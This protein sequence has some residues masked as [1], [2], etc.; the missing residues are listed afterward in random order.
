MNARLSFLD[1][2]TGRLSFDWIVLAALIL[3]TAASVLSL[4]AASV[5]LTRA[6]VAPAACADAPA[7]P[8]LTR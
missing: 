2:E 4:P 1:A 6:G 8:C 3:G 7:T 5:P